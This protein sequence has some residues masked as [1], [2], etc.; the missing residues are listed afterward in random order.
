[1]LK[2]LK[3]LL[4]VVQRE[5]LTAAD[6]AGSLT[7]AE[8][9]VA[10]ATAAL[11]AVEVG[12]KSGLLSADDAQLRRLDEARTDARLRSDRAAALHAALAEKL[13]AAREREADVERRQQYDAAQTQAAEAGRLLTEMYPQLAREIVEVLRVVAEAEIAVEEANMNLPANMPKILGVEASARSTSR[14]DGV[15]SERKVTRWCRLGERTPDTTRD[16]AIV[17]GPDGLGR[18]HIRGLPQRDA[19]VFVKRR[20]MEQTVI[21]ASGRVPDRLAESLALPGLMGGDW[22]FWSPRDLSRPQDVLRHADRL[23]SA[24]LARTSDHLPTVTRLVLA[25]DL[26]P[27]DIRAEMLAAR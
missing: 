22:P 18:R 8:T 21:P 7:E 17:E 26:T 23:A 12:Y 19:V 10:A 6:L 16:D 1:M 14:P 11:E 24:T 2:L 13:A 15:V 27:D 9:E 5:D 3:G 25:E 20:F 4:G